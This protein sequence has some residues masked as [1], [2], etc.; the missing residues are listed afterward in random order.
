M[1]EL[2][3]KMYAKLF[4]NV[5][6]Q[7]A[8][9]ALTLSLISIAIIWI[10]FAGSIS[11]GGGSLSAQIQQLGFVPAAVLI[12]LFLIMFFVIWF[13]LYIQYMKEAEDIYSRLR[14]KIEGAWAAHYDFLI[15]KTYIF[16]SRPLALFNFRINQDKKLEMEFDPSNNT[17]F[18]DVSSNVSQISLRHIGS[19][20]YSLMYFYSNERRLRDEIAVCIEPDYPT[21]DVSRIDVEVFG[22]LFFEEPPKNQKI[23]SMTGSWYDLNG[24]M[25]TLGVLLQGRAKAE[26]AGRLGDYKVKLSSLVASHSVSAKMGD[27][28]FKRM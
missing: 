5:T 25:R 18:N 24:Q 1:A 3:L 28:D 19:N 17:L 9:A 2:L 13:I 10:L 27:V 15:S 8:A 22:M 7:L 12:S 14:E 16:P 26:A 20:K 11:F 6:S 4:Q 23:S 21:H